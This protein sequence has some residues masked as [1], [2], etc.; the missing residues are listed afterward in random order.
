MVALLCFTRLCVRTRP[1]IALEHALASFTALTAGDTIIISV[2]GRPHS[3]TVVDIKPD[4][5][6]VGQRNACCVVNAHLE[7]DFLPPLEQEPESEQALLLSLGEVR[8]GEACAAGCYRYYRVKTLDSGLAFQAEV[9]ARSGDPELVVSTTTNKPALTDCTWKSISSLGTT[10]AASS[11]TRTITVAPSSLGFVVGWYYV[12]V[13]AYGTDATFDVV[14]REVAPPEPEGARAPA[15]PAVGSLS[16]SDPNA[17]K[18]DNCQQFISQKAHSLHTAQ[19]ARLNTYCAQCAKPIRKSDLPTHAHCPTCNLVLHPA[20]MCFTTDMRVMTERGFMSLRQIEA[21]DEDA[22]DQLLYSCYDVAAQALVYRTGKLVYPKGGPVYEL[23]NPASRLSIR[24]TGNHEL[25]V[26]LGRRNGKACDGDDDALPAFKITVDKLLA[27]ESSNPGRTIRFAA[28]AIN[29]HLPAQAHANGANP[30]SLESLDNGEKAAP[31]NWAAA[32]GL[33]VKKLNKTQMRLVLEELHR[34]SGSLLADGQNAIVTRDV[35]F[36]DQLV[37]ACLHAG[38]AASFDEERVKAEHSLTSLDALPD[39]QEP[40]QAAASLWR[41]SYTDPT[42]AAASE[43]D[44]GSACWPSLD[45]A[46]VKAVDYGGRFWCVTVDHPDHLVVVQRAEQEEGDEGEEV[47]FVRAASRPV[48]I[49]QSKHVDLVHKSAPCPECN[50]PVEPALMQLHRR[51]EC[52]M[53]PAQC[54]YCHMEMAHRLVFEHQQIC[55]AQTIVSSK[56]GMSRLEDGRSA[57]YD[58]CEKR[59]SRAVSPVFLTCLLRVACFLYPTCDVS[60]A[61]VARSPC[62]ASGWTSTTRSTTAST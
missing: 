58:A 43:P 51:E 53:R 7:V 1:K 39:S 13:L 41:V 9:T 40:A 21:I 32:L 50:E 4:T 35:S 26:Q 22:R 16:A 15:G 36:R 2:H 28:A 62:R 44:R 3:L 11:H 5:R 34:A 60:P 25:Y 57:V 54:Q 45:L 38:Y 14:L 19:C 20:D 31:A 18:C 27:L 56:R 47:G 30:A 10:G 23:T 37:H 8:A 42:E 48:I 52:K 49:G 29:G 46:D 61:S 55:G 17:R 12:G 33:A 6:M 59:A 24:V